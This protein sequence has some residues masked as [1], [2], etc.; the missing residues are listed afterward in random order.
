MA[1]KQEIEKKLITARVQMLLGQP[2]FGNLACRLILIDG[3]NWIDTCATDGKY[4]YYNRDFVEQMSRP[5]LTFVFSHE[6]L[7]CALA[8]FDRRNGRDPKVWNYATDYVNNLEIYHANVGTPPKTIN[9]GKKEYNCLLDQKYKGMAA[10]QVYDLLIQEQKKNPKAFAGKMGNG[11]FD[12]HADDL[13]GKTP[14]PTGE[15]GPIPMTEDEKERLK[16]EIRSAVIQAARAVEAGQVPG[17]IQRFVSDLTE[18]KMDWRS[19]LQAHI[20]SAIKDDFTFLKPNRKSSVIPYILPGLKNAQRIDV[21]IAIDVSGSMSDDMIRDILSE[22]YGIMTQFDDYVL[23]IWSFD[24]KVYKETYVT[25]TPDNIEE[26]F[27]YKMVGGGGTNFVCNWEFMKEEGIE[28]DRFVMF[29]DGYDMSNE[30]GGQNGNADYCST[31]FVL[32]NTN[33][34]MVAP[35]GDTAYLDL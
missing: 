14:D 4:F 10:E 8:N 30:W 2:F 5:E 23:R 31:L 15:N 33:P 20:Q 22:V 18:P 9:R 12:Q 19:L 34:N 1:T 24:T 6:V 32:H 21:D 13:E 29:T 17:S 11:N 26:I 3:T 16:D 7:H 28:P 25:L 27:E 35:F